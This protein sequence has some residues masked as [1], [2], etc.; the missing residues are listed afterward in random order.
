MSK[1]LHK[2]FVTII[3][4][5][6]VF[7]KWKKHP[8]VEIMWSNYLC[9][10]TEQTLSMFSPSWKLLHWILPYSENAHLHPHSFLT[11]VAGATEKQ[12]QCMLAGLTTLYKLAIV[13]LS[14]KIWT[15]VIISLEIWLLHLTAAFCVIVEL[16][17]A[18]LFF[19]QERI[20]TFCLIE[21]SLIVF[22]TL[23]L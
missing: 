22:H 15:H 10:I 9:V 4:D 13:L 2:I 17:I 6:C 1:I 19:L 21:D 8:Q 14:R 5:F 20:S 18:L 7:L 12:A 16:K 11:N 23:C 3:L